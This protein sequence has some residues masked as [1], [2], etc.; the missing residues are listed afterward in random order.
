MPQSAGVIYLSV[1]IVVRQVSGE[2]L[3][4]FGLAV[5]F[6]NS[7][8]CCLVTIVLGSCGFVSVSALSF[9]ALPF[10]SSSFRPTVTLIVPRLLAVITL[11]LRPVLLLG[12]GGVCVRGK[13]CIASLPFVCDPFSKGTAIRFLAEQ[14]DESVRADLRRRDDGIEGGDCDSADGSLGNVDSNRDG[15]ELIHDR[16]KEVVVRERQ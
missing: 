13:C 15:A 1:V 7:L 12:S 4:C 3:I 6:C 14:F 8:P 9:R 5:I 2:F 10:F 16:G 11:Y